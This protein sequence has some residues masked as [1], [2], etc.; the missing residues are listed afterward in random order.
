MQQHLIWAESWG[1]SRWEQALGVLQ[2]LGCVGRSQP[3]AATLGRAQIPALWLCSA[4][5]SSPAPFALT[6]V[7]LWEEGGASETL[8]IKQKGVKLLVGRCSGQGEANWSLFL[9]EKCCQKFYQL[10]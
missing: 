5:G 4:P 10:S 1:H 3:G 8:R 2:R 6:F 9:T 7:V